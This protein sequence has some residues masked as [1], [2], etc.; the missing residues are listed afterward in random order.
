[1]FPTNV[2]TNENSI[3]LHVVISKMA[4]IWK[5]SEK[6]RYKKAK[7]S[8]CVRWATLFAKNN[9]TAENRYF[10]ISCPSG[11]KKST[12]IGFIVYIQRLKDKG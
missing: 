10:S 1:M 7:Y 8:R 3:F 5:I 6:F 11:L 4:K 12:N 9:N 2:F